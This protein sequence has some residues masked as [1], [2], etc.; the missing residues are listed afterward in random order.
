M[1]FEEVLP[2]LREGKFIKRACW[3]G[4]YLCEWYGCLMEQYYSEVMGR[5]YSCP[6]NDFYP[7]NVYNNDVLAEDWE[8]IE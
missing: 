6:A 5:W 7:E 4:R 8:V 2:A 1:K 3:E